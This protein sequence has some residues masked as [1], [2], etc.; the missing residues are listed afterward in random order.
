MAQ[1]RWRGAWKMPPVRRPMPVRGGVP[2]RDVPAGRC[3]NTV[4]VGAWCVRVA[5]GARGRGR[6]MACGAVGRVRA[7]R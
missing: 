4:V 2:G 5:R 1:A 6:V 7:Y 3:S